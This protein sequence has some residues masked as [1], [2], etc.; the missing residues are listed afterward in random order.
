MFGRRLGAFD[1]TRRWSEFAT[2]IAD[3]SMLN[4]SNNDA[5]ARQ[6][7]CAWVFSIQRPH[8]QRASVAILLGDG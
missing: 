7:M 2:G 3:R 5:P 4:G 1:T 8:E 6:A